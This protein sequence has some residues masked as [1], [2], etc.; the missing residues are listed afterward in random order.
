MSTIVA[1]IKARAAEIGFVACGISDL[2]PTAH[3]ADFDRWIASGYGGT[4]RYLHRQARKRK[5]PSKIAP[6]GRS[7]VVVLDNYYY[8]DSGDSAPKVA[9]YALG[10][11]YHQVTGARLEL[12][13][14]TMRELG[15]G[16]TRVFTDAGPVPERELAQR[17]GLGW[18]GKNCMLIRP[19]VG[20]WF[21]IGSVLTD[22]ELPADQPFVTDHCGSCR[23]CLDACPTEAFVEPGLLDATRCISYQ[24]IE[25]PGPTATELVPL[26]E[27]WGFGCD[28]CNEVC[29]WNERFA[30]P[31]SV[32]QFQPIPNSPAGRANA[33]EGM[34]EVEF[35]ARFGDTPF[36]RPGLEKM[37]SNWQAAAGSKP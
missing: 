9:R 8:G 13:A 29:P 3:G 14:D 15:A 24:T 37:K 1:A 20:S 32:T 18:I 34:T 4:M 7:I 12:L 35:L 10:R 31:T 26:L 27:G 21:F 2:S 19:G 33:F 28:I 17:A 11:D 6:E 30:S 25:K 16:Y 36:E 5:D 23:R 22:L